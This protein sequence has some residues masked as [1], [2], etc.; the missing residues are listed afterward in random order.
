MNTPLPPDAL[1]L[2]VPPVV[3]ITGVEEVVS[4]TAEEGC[5]IVVVAVAEHWLISVTVTV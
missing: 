5:V 2:A 4:E 1:T 3:Q